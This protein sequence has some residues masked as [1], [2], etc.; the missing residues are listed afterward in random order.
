MYSEGKRS[1]VKHLDFTFLD[2]ICLEL[3]LILA[4]AWRFDG[5]WLFDEDIYQRL[6]VM[7][8]V[9]H[10]VVVFFLEPYKGILR[11]N[12]FQEFR[13]T[14][15]SAVVCFGGVLV[16][17][18][19]IKQSVL[20]SRQLLFVFLIFSVIMIYTERVI[21]KRVIRAR[22]LQD[23]NKAL[24]TVV[25][26]S[27]NVERCLKEIAQNKY[28]NFKV[29]G[30]VVVDQSLEGTLIM[31][32]PVIANADNFLDYVRTHVVDE[33][34][35]DGNTRESSEALASALVELGTTVHMSLVHSKVLVPNRQLDNYGNYVVLTSSMRIATNRQLFIKRTM[36][37]LGSLIGL[38]LVGIA[39]IVFAPIIKIQ[40]P[41]PVFYKQVRIGKNGRRFNFYKF[42]SMHVGADAMLDKL[43]EE[44]EMKGNMFKMENDPRIIPIGHFMRKYSI[45]ELP[46]FWNVLKGDMSLVGT[47][48]PTEDEYDMYEYHHKARLGIRPGLTGMWQ[49]SG[50]SDIT[51]FEEVVELDTEY[52]MNW[53]LGLDIKILFKTVGVVF[54]GKGSK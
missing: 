10:I 26:E 18:Y 14:L 2:L 42:R 1:W 6:A 41:G 11:R 46:Q 44:N 25:A 7:V 38:I 16:Y 45:D 39:Y 15:T 34:F 3:S 50:R 20:Y 43:K 36:D 19:A 49:V 30:V 32:I 37:I 8:L 35:I 13:A 23:K 51:D 27:S 52:I 17:M 24:M 48:P 54:S 9:I 33:V 22:K 5:K 40:S 47:R 21:W 31:G 53:T 28:T 29:T 12:K 4:Y